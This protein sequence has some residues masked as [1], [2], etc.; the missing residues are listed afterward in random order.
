MDRMLVVVFDSEDKAYQGKSALLDL[1]R[2]GSIN[3]YGYAVVAKNA[4]G[5]TSVKDTSNSGPLGTLAGTS[6]GS[7]IG[8]LG[9][10][11]GVV[12][13]ATAGMFAGATAD[14]N[15]VGVAGD[16]IDDV[17]K[18]L[19]PGKVAVVA[20]IE[21]NWVTPVNTRMTALGGNVYRRALSDVRRTAFNEDMAAMKADI[22]QMKSEL[23]QAEAKH[24]AMLQTDIERLQ[25]KLSDAEQKAED[26]SHAADRAAQ[27]KL[28]AL[29]NKGA[30]ALRQHGLR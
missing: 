18:A 10:P 22:N 19:T 7:L 21:E 28:A 6:L 3:V 30:E 20:E 29:R 9:G 13:G 23:S 15:N 4:D 17:T 25:T 5:K 11:A 26:M 1:D 27:A 2:D 24:K 8:L 16:F 12:A 14:L